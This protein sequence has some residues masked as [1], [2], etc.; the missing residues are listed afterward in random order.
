MYHGIGHPNL[1]EM[2]RSGYTTRYNPAQPASTILM[3]NWFENQLPEM[4]EDAY[5][6]QSLN[7]DIL[8][9]DHPQSSEEVSLGDWI[10]EE[11]VCQ[12]D[13]LPSTTY[14]NALENPR[15]QLE[16]LGEIRDNLAHDVNFYSEIEDLEI[17]DS[18]WH[19]YEI[20]HT[21]SERIGYRT[22]EFEL[23]GE[24]AEQQ[25]RARPYMTSSERLTRW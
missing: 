25:R 21:M 7:T 17:R 16:E 23:F 3:Y 2:N 5:D 8:P 18:I 19:G 24:E 15:Q 12:I 6:S 4:I 10:D 13:V 9:N 11:I 14:P 22:N 20:M 1:D